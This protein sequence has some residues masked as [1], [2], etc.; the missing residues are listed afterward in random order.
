MTVMP[1]HCL[2]RQIISDVS[3]N[4]LASKALCVHVGIGSANISSDVSVYR[5][6]GRTPTY[7]DQ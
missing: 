2:Y 1:E 3:F 4:I 6:S 5:F 7:A